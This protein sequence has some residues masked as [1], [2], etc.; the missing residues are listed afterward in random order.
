MS[1]KIKLTV[2]VEVVVR[3]RDAR[4]CGILDRLSKRPGMPVVISMSRLASE[5]GSSPDTLRRAVA[6]CRE[7]GYLSVTE[8]YF[9]NGAQLENTYTLTTHGIAIA[10]AAS[11]AGMV[12]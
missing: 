4:L 11:A 7:E 2:P 9:D 5:L 3:D 8:N 12:A 6:S 10:K 1:R